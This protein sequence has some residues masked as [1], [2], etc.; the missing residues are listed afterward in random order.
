[1]IKVNEYFEGQVKSMACVNGEGE[2]TVGVMKQG[3]YVFSTSK[4]EEMTVIS[5]ALEVLLP[6]A[7]EAQVFH[8]NEVFSVPANDK[9]TAK[10]LEETIYTCRYQ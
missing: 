9:F 6:G 10:A 5:G 7:V 8:K 1:M 4:K 2:L 3:E